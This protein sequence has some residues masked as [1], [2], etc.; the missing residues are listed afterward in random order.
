MY[1]PLEYTLHT[2]GAYSTL[3]T[4]Y[5]RLQSG[6]DITVQ[7]STVLSSGYILAPVQFIVATYWPQYTGYL[8]APEQFTVAIYWPQYSGTICGKAEKVAW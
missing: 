2:A 7:Y 6:A 4:A 5:W 3:I 1:Y 8:L